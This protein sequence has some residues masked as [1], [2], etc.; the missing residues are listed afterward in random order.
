MPKLNQKFISNQ[1]MKNDF[2]AAIEGLATAVVRCQASIIIP[3]SLFT[4]EGLEVAGNSLNIAD[5]SF[6]ILCAQK[7]KL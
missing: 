4:R 5:Y 1:S 7:Q 6:A 3:T 2:V